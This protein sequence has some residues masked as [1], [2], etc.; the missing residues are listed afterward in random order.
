MKAANPPL[1]V[2]YADVIEEKR[3]FIFHDPEKNPFALRE[4]NSDPISDSMNSLILFEW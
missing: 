4:R 2:P 3:A 1:Y